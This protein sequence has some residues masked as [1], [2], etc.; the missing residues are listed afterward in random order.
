[1][2]LHPYDV[3]IRP[4]LTE[5][6][7]AGT[8]LKNR[9]YIF[10]VSP[11]SNKVQIRRAVESAFGVK[12]LSV[13]TVNVLGKRKRLRSREEGKRADWKKAI[14]TLAEGNEINLI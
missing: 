12:V 6:A 13:N 2:S 7:S 14:V 10:K 11:G 8:D 3:L 5:R 9:K 1:M 4:L